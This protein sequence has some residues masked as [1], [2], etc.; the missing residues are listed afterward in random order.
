MVTVTNSHYEY[1]SLFVGKH[2]KN[3]Q[4]SAF[5]DVCWNILEKF[6]KVY[7]NMVFSFCKTNKLN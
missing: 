4:I 1:I 2:G 5:I 3:K 7:F 6:E